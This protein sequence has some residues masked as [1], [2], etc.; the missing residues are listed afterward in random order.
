MDITFKF[1]EARSRIFGTIHRPVAVV[2]FQSCKSKKWVEL[3]MLVDSGADYTLLPWF[4]VKDL[5]ID[6]KKDCDL[7]ETRG[8]GGTTTVYVYKKKLNVKLG[9]R[10]FRVP[11]G[12]LKGKDIPPLLGRHKFM[13]KIKTT[14]Y[15][16]KTIFK[17]S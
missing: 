4:L 6:L 17:D 11:V 10:S 1:E 9:D 2:E 16:H 5:E 3:K 14:F 15:H 8:V 7:F 12:F 13:E